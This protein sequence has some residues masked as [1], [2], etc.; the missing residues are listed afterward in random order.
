MADPNAKQ[1]DAIRRLSESATAQAAETLK[2]TREAIA[3]RLDQLRRKVG[4][5]PRRSSHADLKAVTR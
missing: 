4:L 5:D 3:H 1:K 2:E